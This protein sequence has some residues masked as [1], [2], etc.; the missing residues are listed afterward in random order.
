MLWTGI[1]VY[2]VRE[3][4]E[5][6]EIRH[7]YTYFWFLEHRTPETARFYLEYQLYPATVSCLEHFDILYPGTSLPY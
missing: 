2:Q 5:L 6:R 3:G 4:A 7:R 1:G